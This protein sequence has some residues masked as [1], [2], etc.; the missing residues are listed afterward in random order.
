MEDE[1]DSPKVPISLCKI[2]CKFIHEK[3][4][5][6]SILH[7]VVLIEGTLLFQAFAALRMPRNRKIRSPPLANVGP[8]N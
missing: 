3:K 5:R 2:V 4:P 1:E 6:I 8:Q 7:F